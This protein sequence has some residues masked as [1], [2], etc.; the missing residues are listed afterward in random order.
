[1]TVLTNPKSINN[2]FAYTANDQRKT[3][4][5]P[6]SGSYLYS[7]D[8]ER[9]LKTIQFPSGKLITNT[10]TKGLLTSTT[11]PEGT[12]TFQYGCSSLLSKA[13]RGTESIA[14]TYDGTLLKTDTRIGLLNQTISYA[15][16][17]D[18]KLASLTYAGASYSLLYDNDEENLGSHLQKSFMKNR[19]LKNLISLSVFLLCFADIS[20]AR[21][22]TKT[23]QDTEYDNLGDL[24][25]KLTKR[26]QH[27]T[28]RMPNK[29]LE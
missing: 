16:N 18:F 7:Y 24:K 19:T 8:K 11:M 25:T 27:M 2:T 6:M 28:G 17:N 26:L 29:T 22:S 23:Y 10:Y 15:Y 5:T 12:T 21:L 9:K 3:W 20:E 13:I 4:L 14:Y 1:M